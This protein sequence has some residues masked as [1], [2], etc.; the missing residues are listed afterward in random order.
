MAAVLTRTAIPPGGEGEIEIVFDSETKRGRQ[1]RVV[2]VVSNDPRNSSVDL[3]LV[4]MVEVEFVFREKYLQLGR[5]YKSEGITMSARLDVKD[6]ET[7][8]VVDLTTTSPLITARVKENPEARANNQYE[9]EVTVLPGVTG[10]RVRE[11]VIAHSNLDSRPVAELNVS[12]SVLADVEIVP[13]ALTFTVEDAAA[14]ESGLTKTLR[15]AD[16]RPGYMLE[17]VEVND[18]KGHLSVDIETSEDGRELRLRV[19]LATGK[20][21]A[22]RKQSGILTITTRDPAYE[23]ILV[24]YT[25]FRRD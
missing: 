11:K 24:P 2:T 8:Q 7:T 17:I 3:R 25:V 14:A 23:E 21:S 9:I 18:N 5:F 22:D 1:N 13:G 4:G 16:H 19:T 20:L 15:I 10:G 12:G 6:V